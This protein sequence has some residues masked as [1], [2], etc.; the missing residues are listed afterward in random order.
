MHLDLNF[1]MNEIF[2]NLWQ[3]SAPAPGKTLHTFG[4]HTLVLCAKEYQPRGKDFQGLRIIHAPNDDNF[5]RPPTKDELHIAIQAAQEVKRDFLQGKKI[6]ITCMAGRN[7]SGLV[8]AF[9]LH[10]LTG[11][12]GLECANLI[13]QKREGALGNP[14]FMKVLTAL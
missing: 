2:P 11:Q 13:K 6:L 9:A 12:S 3:G 14:G 10:L 8:M 1:S 5:T 7:R 4:F